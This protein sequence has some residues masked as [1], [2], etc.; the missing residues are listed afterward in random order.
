MKISFVLFQVGCSSV[1]KAEY[2]QN[3][4][5]AT[6]LVHNSYQHNLFVYDSVLHTVMK[7]NVYLIK[8]LMQKGRAKRHSDGLF[9]YKCILNMVQ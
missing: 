4:T 2:L 1:K 8:Q 5:L 6:T 9:F 3:T 7:C